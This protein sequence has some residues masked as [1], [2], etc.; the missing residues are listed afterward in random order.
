MDKI[1]AEI[2]RALGINM[3]W[4]IHLSSDIQIA[5]TVML[6][7]KA[8]VGIFVFKEGPRGYVLVIKDHSAFLDMLRKSKGANSVDLILD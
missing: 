7:P 2:M 1:C 8:W 3:S 5:G 6:N 4:L